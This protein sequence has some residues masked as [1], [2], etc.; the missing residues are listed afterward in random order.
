MSISKTIDRTNILQNPK[1]IHRCDNALPNTKFCLRFVEHI[2]I[3]YIISACNSN[4]VYIKL[5]KK[6]VLQLFFLYLL[7][8]QCNI[9][10]CLIS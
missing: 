8:R 10:R 7:D 4:K 6:V 1:L 3:E 5:K 2:G 9:I